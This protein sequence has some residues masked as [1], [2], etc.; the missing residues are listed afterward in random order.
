[1]GC[2]A[3]KIVHHFAFNDKG[4]L[5]DFS[6]KCD[7]FDAKKCFDCKRDKWE[8]FLYL[9]T[10]LVCGQDCR[11]FCINHMKYANRFCNV[12]GHVGTILR[13][14]SSPNMTTILITLSETGTGHQHPNMHN[15]ITTS[16]KNHSSDTR[17]K[18]NSSMCIRKQKQSNRVRSQ[19]N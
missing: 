9:H 5:E 16:K 10:C 3:E 2:K 15:N 1:M 11:T 13:C 14:R 19:Q 12:P 6:D 17:N 4:M 8:G 7:H 18:R